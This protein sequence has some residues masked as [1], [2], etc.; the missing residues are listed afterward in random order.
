MLLYKRVTYSK[1][2]PLSGLTLYVGVNGSESTTATLSPHFVGVQSNGQTDSGN[3]AVF[4][5]FAERSEQYVTTPT[6]S[7]GGP[8]RQPA[9]Y[10]HTHHVQHLCMPCSGF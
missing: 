3:V 8:A 5:R 4:Y 9:S 6:C 1:S 2:T 7:T 10:S